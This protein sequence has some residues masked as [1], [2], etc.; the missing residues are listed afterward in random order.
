MITKEEDCWKVYLI[1]CADNS[2]YC[3]IA[4][5]VTGRI[6]K[7]NAGKG[8]KYTR[9]RG[10]VEWV[11][12]SSEMSKGDALKLEYYIKKLSKEDKV[13]ALRERA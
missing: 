2:L 12:E 9:Y 5:D 4:K 11:A 1:K 8:A 3:G 6:E 13:R 7:H 10:P